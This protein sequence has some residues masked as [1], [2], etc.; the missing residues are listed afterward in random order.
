MSSV[1]NNLNYKRRSIHH[2]FL[3]NVVAHLK[4]II[5]CANSMFYETS[6][7]NMSSLLPE[8]KQIK[9]LKVFLLQLILNTISVW[10]RTVFGAQIVQQKSGQVRY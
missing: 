2:T 5:F 10:L 4:L 7:R 1:T 3:Q 9:H 6:Q 8:Q